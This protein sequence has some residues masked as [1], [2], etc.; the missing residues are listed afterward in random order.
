MRLLTFFV[1]VSTLSHVVNAEPR[2]PAG[3]A[4]LELKRC[5]REAGFELKQEYIKPSEL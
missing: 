2:D 1:C 5:C 4:A 3:C